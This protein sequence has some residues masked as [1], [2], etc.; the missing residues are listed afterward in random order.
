MECPDHRTVS[1]GACLA[2]GREVCERCLHGIDDPG[3]FECPDCGEF[4]VA[5]FDEDLGHLLDGEPPDEAP[6]EL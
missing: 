2:C 6:P 1:I 3:T 5:L 4:G